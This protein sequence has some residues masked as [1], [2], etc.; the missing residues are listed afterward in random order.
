[1]TKRIAVPSTVFLKETKEKTSVL[2]QQ[3]SRRQ[4]TIGACIE[5]LKYTSNPF[6]WILNS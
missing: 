2:T 1:M 4:S 3:K 6:E 5:E